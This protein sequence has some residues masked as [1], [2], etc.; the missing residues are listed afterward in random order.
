ML[1]MMFDH[2]RGTCLTDGD[3]YCYI[4]GSDAQPNAW[5]VERFDT[6]TGKCTE[7]ADL[8]RRKAIYLSSAVICR[9]SGGK[10]HKI[11]LI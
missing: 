3:R 6:K 10:G 2:R 8:P 4:L 9:V 7:L 5:K 11:Y 1:E